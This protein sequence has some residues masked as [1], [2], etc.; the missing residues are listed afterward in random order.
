MPLQ[1]PGVATPPINPQGG[2][3]P[4][5]LLEQLR[6]SNIFRPQP[7]V[8]PPP[9]PSLET[10]VGLG[11]GE[12]TVAGYQP[13]TAA[14]DR[15]NELLQNYPE[16]ESRGIIEKI[17]LSMMALNDPRLVA[18][19]MQQPSQEQEM[20]QQQIGPAQAAMTGEGQRNVNMRQIADMIMTGQQAGERIDISRAAQELSEWKSKHPNVQFKTREDGMIVGISPLDPT[21]VIE[22]G[23][24]S[25][26]LTD[27]EKIDARIEA[28]ELAEEG[29]VGR[30]ATATGERK[31]AAELR[32]DQR[33]GAATLQEERLRGRPSKPGVLTESARTTKRLSAAEELKNRDPNGLGKWVTI[34]GRKVE[35][36]EPGKVKAWWPDKKGPTPEEHKQIM[37]ILYPGREPKTGANV[38]DTKADPKRQRA[39]DQ[40]KTDGKPVTE[41]MIEWMVGKI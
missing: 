31:T 34:D 4:D 22:T 32:E 17:A 21:N 5:Q 20:W 12:E 37:N 7:P 2:G 40:L 27:Q 25:G 6:M 39:I 8:A 28:A 1:L 41:A 36:A 10:G 24:Q 35:V 16:R 29:R 19:I 26:D 9:S 18:Q 38:V 33:V 14:L 15:F 3:L 13:E 30:A 11:P 23:V